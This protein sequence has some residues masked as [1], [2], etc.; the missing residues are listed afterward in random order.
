MLLFKSK[1]FSSAKDSILEL[2]DFPTDAKKIIES[3]RH[4]LVLFAVDVWGYI[5][6]AF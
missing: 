3:I 5:I 1:L 2:V 4:D 6:H